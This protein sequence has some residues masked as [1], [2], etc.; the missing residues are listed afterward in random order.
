MQY[1]HIV[2]LIDDYL[3]RLTKARQVLLALDAPSTSAPTRASQPAQKK[4]RPATGRES[5]ATASLKTSPRQSK[6]KTTATSI[7]LE[8]SKPAI[9]QRKRTSDS[10][11]ASPLL[12]NQL[13]AEEQLEEAYQEP[14][15]QGVSSAITMPTIG[16]AP[17]RRKWSK[18]HAPVARALGGS[19]SAAPVF[20]PAEQIRQEQSQRQATSEME[21]EAGGSN[22]STTAVPVAA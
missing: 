19:V 16:K 9:M 21:H 17:T 10:V 2:N 3:N 7:E 20:I 14:V 4:T 11:V 5:A 15:A 18:H 22:G 13:F 1:V 6:K 8:A 12:L